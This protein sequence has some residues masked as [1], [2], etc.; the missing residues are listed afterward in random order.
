LLKEE[1]SEKSAVKISSIRKK[2]KNILCN[3]GGER[4]NLE[5][6]D[7]TARSDKAI[8]VAYRMTPEWNIFVK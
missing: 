3:A 1:L 6:S 7:R 8:F 2:K 5:L 4:K